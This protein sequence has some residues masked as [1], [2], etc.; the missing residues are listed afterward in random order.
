MP[1]PLFSE[2]DSTKMSGKYV[3]TTITAPAA[4][5]IHQYRRR[6]RAAPAGR[7]RVAGGRPAE[8]MVSS[9]R[10][11]VSTGRS[12]L[13]QVD[14]VGRRPLLR[15][16]GQQRLPLAGE[17]GEV[18]L[19]VEVLLHEPQARVGRGGGQDVVEDDVDHGADLGRRDQGAQAGDVKHRRAG[20]GRDVRARLV[21]LD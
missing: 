18:E 21:D 3:R 16:A 14:V 5:V 17:R 10:V 19:A 13:A 7:P 4:A 9:E 15:G 12:V 8:V 2:L 1:W 11:R 20:L 6:Q